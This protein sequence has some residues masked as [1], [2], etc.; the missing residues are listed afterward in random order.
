MQNFLGTSFYYILI[1]IQDFLVTSFYYILTLLQ[2]FLGT[3]FFNILFAV[4]DFPC[5]LL[6]DVL[7]YFLGFPGIYIFHMPAALFNI[8]FFFILFNGLFFILISFLTTCLFFSDSSWYFLF[9]TFTSL[10]R[11][12]NNTFFLNEHL[13]AVLALTVQSTFINCIWKYRVSGLAL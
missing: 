11:I 5:T 2:R 4:L 7:F 12:A 6:F 10:F 3:S 1:G 8:F 9:L 13:M